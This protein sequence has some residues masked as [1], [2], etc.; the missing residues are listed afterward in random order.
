MLS[1]NKT[2]ERGEVENWEKIAHL[3]PKLHMCPL[4]PKGGHIPQKRTYSSIDHKR[5]SCA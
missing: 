1:F 2:G 3:S 5:G 4:S